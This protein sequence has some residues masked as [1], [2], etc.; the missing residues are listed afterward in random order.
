MKRVR[1]LILTSLPLVMGAAFLL[2]HS[3]V[4]PDQEASAQPAFYVALDADITDG[5]PC[6]EIDNEREVS[7]GQD[8][9][10]AVCV[11]GIPGP[12]GSLTMSVFYDDTLNSAPEISCPSGNCFDD[13]PDANVGTTVWGDGFGGGWDCNIFDLAQPIGDRL[14]DV[15]GPGNGEA[16]MSCWTLTGP[17]TLGDNETDGVLEV[18]SFHALAAGVETLA[19]GG[20]SISD[21]GGV[22]YGGCNPALGVEIDCFNATIYKG[23]T[24]TPFP[25]PTPTFTPT[26][27]ITPTPT[28]TPTPTI[29]PTITNTP[30]ITPTPSGLDSDGD[31]VIDFFDNCD[32][33]PNPDQANSD[34]LPFENSTIIPGLDTSLPA[35][36]ELGDACDSDDDNDQWPDVFEAMGCLS[37]PTDQGGDVA[38]DD[39]ENG[40]SALPFGSDAADDGP[41]WDSDGDGALDGIECLFAS[42]PLDWAS[43]PPWGMPDDEDGDG[44]PLAIENALGSS[45]TDADS[46]GDTVPDG[47]EVRGWGSSPIS[48]D[49]DFDGCQDWVE[50]VDINGDGKAALVDVW[51]VARMAFDIVPKHGALD[52]NKDGLLNV[53]DAYTAA[54]NSGLV[55]PGAQCP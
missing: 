52:I 18:V 4:V 35:S 2:L 49:T 29:T 28:D 24:R 40:N 12:L 16:W 27:T 51:W 30:T 22:E 33:H 17:Y 39:N 15:T 11:F 8:Y 44:L 19:I 10:V 1:L 26:P 21:P 20:L 43:K 5:G 36:D 34:A 47:V 46:D 45:D 55:R 53:L 7:I 37:G 31:T 50:I 3:S 48:V 25:S 54:I 41:S 13:N 38:F 14:P 23:V 32:S 42:D 6:S 9:Q